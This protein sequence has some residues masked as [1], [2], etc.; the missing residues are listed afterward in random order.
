MRM[1]DVAVIL[2][3]LWVAAWGCRGGDP[4]LDT[5]PDEPF[6]PKPVPLTIKFWQMEEPDNVVGDGTIWQ[7]RFY[8]EKLDK[9][10]NR[11]PPNYIDKVECFVGGKLVDAYDPH[12]LNPE[13]IWSGYYS[14]TWD[15]RSL[16]DAW[17]FTCEV[18]YFGRS[19]GRK[20]VKVRIWNGDLPSEAVGY[21]EYNNAKL[22]R[23]TRN[24]LQQRDSPP[25]RYPGRRIYYLVEHTETQSVVDWT[26]AYMGK[27]F[28]LTFI[29][30]R[31]YAVRPLLIFVKGHCCG[32]FYNSIYPTEFGPNTYEIYLAAVGVDEGPGTHPFVTCHEVG[33]VFQL[34]HQYAGN[35]YRG[36]CMADDGTDVGPRLH[37]YQ[38]KA[39]QMIYSKPP[40]Y[41]W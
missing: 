17:G 41:S 37:P 9:G 14:H 36:S 16:L 31:D 20:K 6:H 38:Q 18:G 26:L 11:W 25:I 5:L 34:P 24:F 32:A 21:F 35:Y 2:A 4:G 23:I 27:R 13:D 39:V 22:E 28:G 15:N 1:R 29:S 33:H 19:E 12:D 7:V 40:G 10:D 30:T 8:V 3:G